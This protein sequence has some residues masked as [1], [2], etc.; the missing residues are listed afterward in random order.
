MHSNEGA[1]ASPATSICDCSHEHSQHVYAGGCKLCK[2]DGFSHKKQAPKYEPS[3]PVQFSGAV[4]PFTQGQAVA[5][6]T[7]GQGT[8]YKAY[9]NQAVV[10]F[11]AGKKRLRRVLSTTLLQSDHKPQRRVK[12]R[13]TA[14]CAAQPK[15]IVNF[16]AEFL[17]KQAAKFA[18]WYEEPKP[19]EP[20]RID[21]TV[22]KYDHR[23][24]LLPTGVANRAAHIQETGPCTVC[25][26][27]GSGACARIVDADGSIR[28]SRDTG[29]RAPV[30]THYA[31]AACA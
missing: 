31:Y 12:Y 2:C 27:N 26:C 28:P 30:S 14:H 21:N 11:N 10:S 5:H 1:P 9:G 17:A 16:S 4:S 7:F 15:Y 8:I 18:G 22:R 19:Y 23:G 20:T 25:G 29:F 24:I 13:E 3:T 6:A